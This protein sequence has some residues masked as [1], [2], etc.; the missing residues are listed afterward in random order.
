MDRS[1][2]V[3]TKMLAYVVASWILNRD[4]KDEK[5]EQQNSVHN[6]S[7]LY[8][9]HILAA[10]TDT[11][12]DTH[13]QDQGLNTVTSRM[14]CMT[15]TTHLTATKSTN[16]TGKYNIGSRLSYSCRSSLRQVW[17]IAYHSS[18]KSESMRKDILHNTN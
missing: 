13:V 2:F 7:N 9:L 16:L 6:K 18:S 11:T 3:L 8:C 10:T 14:I 15:L 5:K 1:F 4:R 17:N 12:E